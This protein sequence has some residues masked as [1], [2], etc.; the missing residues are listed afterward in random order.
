MALICAVE[1]ALAALAAQ[2]PF[3]VREAVRNWEM[4]AE[5]QRAFFVTPLEDVLAWTGTYTDGT[6]A[7]V[8]PL[9][10]RVGAATYILNVIGHRA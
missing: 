3:I 6:V 4:S 10:V 8:G 5:A 1:L 2:E 7:D 9:A